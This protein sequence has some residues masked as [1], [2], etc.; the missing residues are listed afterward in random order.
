MIVNSKPY[1]ERDGH[2]FGIEE[3]VRVR[4]DTGSQPGQFEI[5]YEIDTVFFAF[6]VLRVRL[7]GL[8]HGYGWLAVR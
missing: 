7:W 1:I 2:Q 6:P 3:R 8:R 4:R 5:L